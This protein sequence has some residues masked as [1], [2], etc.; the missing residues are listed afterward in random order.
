MRTRS[1]L[2]LAIVLLPAIW[3]AATVAGQY[4]VKH[5]QAISGPS[6]FPGGCP[7]AILDETRIPGAE[8]EPAITVNPAHPRNIIATWQQDLGQGAA[9]T[10]L[11]GTSRD[12]GRTWK[13]VTVP[14]LSRCTGGTFDSAT[15]P[16][17]SAGP[18]GTVYFTGATLSF[19]SEPE[20]A[21]LFASRSRDRGRSWAP[22]V[23]YA[24]PSPRL[25]REVITADPIR[26]GNAYVVWWER[27]PLMP[28]V[29]STHQFAR[30]TDG[31]AT[32]STPTTVDA[33]PDGALDQSAEI[34]VLPNGSLLATFARIQIEGTAAVQQLLASRSD[35]QGQ[36]WSEPVEVVSQPIQPYL[37]PETGDQLPNQDLTFHSAAIAP[38]GT[39]YVAWDR[40]SSPTTGEIDIVKSSDG[41]VTWSGPTTLPGVS[42]FAFQPAIAVDARGTVGVTWYDT[43]ND[44]PGDAPLTT[45]VWF[46]HSRDGGTSW[47]ELHLA[48]PFDFRT[49]P[50]PTGFGRLGEYQGL[51]GLRTRGFAAAFT[52]A[53]PQAQ[54][55]PTDIFFARIGPRHH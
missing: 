27:D 26:P 3:P 6:P 30:T 48:G 32:W 53:A 25:E 4:K 47:R 9:R 36:T 54:D 15:D 12:G 31:G 21:A 38:D 17:L 33:A 5:L 29:G 10:D 34:H 55:G 52:Q 50:R 43:R 41:G 45:D 46:A 22:P 13:R 2:I 18:D 49:A 39:V 11:I 51:A 8:I 19:A 37:D 16:W 7:G 44:L 28:F 24:G 23:P 35:D 40:A 42:A 1:L 20:S 14:G